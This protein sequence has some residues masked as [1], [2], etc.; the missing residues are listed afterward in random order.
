MSAATLR[1]LYLPRKQPPSARDREIYELAM[2]ER[3][4]QVEL[5][6]RF[7]LS[8]GRIAQIVQKVEDW[9]H[10]M[11][12]QSDAS[13]HAA[14]TAG[15]EW[16]S[17][18]RLQLAE[19]MAY[20]R[21]EFVYGQAVEAWKESRRDSSEVRT[22]QTGKGILE[23][24]ITKTQ[25]GK[26][27]LLHQAMRAALA[28]ARLLG[29]D[30][31]GREKRK[32]LEQATRETTN[33]RDKPREKP[34]ANAVAAG[35]AYGEDREAKQKAGNWPAQRPA[36]HPARSASLSPGKREDLEMQTANNGEDCRTKPSG[37]HTHDELMEQLQAILAGS[38]DDVLK[39]AA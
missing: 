3:L 31:T 28:S 36:A 6:Q 32:S 33:I 18:E 27:G 15:R 14:D 22:R 19:Q 34:A 1:D 5:A 17:G 24:R 30:V 2:E 16:T 12:R 9:V 25:T 29:V 10:A 23:E 38:V 39:S 20:E 7:G 26:A 37:S 4:P 35:G 13:A 11:L 21:V 8:Q